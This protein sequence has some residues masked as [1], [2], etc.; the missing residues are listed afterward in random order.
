M[1]RNNDILIA[2]QNVRTLTQLNK[3]GVHET[4]LCDKCRKPETFKHYILECE[5]E[6]SQIV[7]DMCSTRNVTL[8]MKSVL[9]NQCTINA[10][11]G[12]LKRRL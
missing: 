7:R 10:I 11:I 12:G 3:I 5:N 2:T 9:Q 4:G 8:Q 6:M 1:K